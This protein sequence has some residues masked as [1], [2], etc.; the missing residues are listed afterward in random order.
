[1]SLA[2]LYVVSEFSTDRPDELTSLLESWERM[3][4][5]FLPGRGL[6][7]EV[8]IDAIVQHRPAARILELG[9][10]PG[11]TLRRLGTRLSDGALVGVDN[12]P[13]LRKIHATVTPVSLS[14]PVVNADL[15][16]SSWVRSVEGQIEPTVVLAIQVLHYFAP[17]RFV[18]LLGEIRRAVGDGGWLV[19]VDHVPASKLEDDQVSVAGCGDGEEIAG[20]RDPWGRW[21]AEAGRVET[22]DD[23][24]GARE[25]LSGSWPASA[26]YHPDEA[27]LDEHLCEVG[28][29]VLRVRQRSG[30]SLLTVAQAG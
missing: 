1:M 20:R 15:N 9:S 8:A 23:A 14:I 16:R 11:N 12:D 5:H 25:G 29:D 3:S 21:W 22:L 17:G 6:L 19:H 27:R 26:E 18:E 7:I 4:D 10:G 2:S 24:F 13:V 30:S 28:F